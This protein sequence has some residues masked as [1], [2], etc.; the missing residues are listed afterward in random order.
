MSRTARNRSLIA[1]D[2]SRALRMRATPTA[3]AVL[4]GISPAAIGRLRFT[5]WRRSDSK[6]RTSFSR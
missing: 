4:S 1:S 6:S 2:S 5:G 3:A